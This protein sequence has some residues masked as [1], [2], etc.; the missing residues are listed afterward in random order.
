MHISIREARRLL[1]R[2]GCVPVETSGRGKHEKWYSPITKQ[3]FHIPRGRIVKGTWRG[4]L[5]QAGI[6]GKP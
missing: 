4:I 1:R 5:K 6:K 2:H 3:R